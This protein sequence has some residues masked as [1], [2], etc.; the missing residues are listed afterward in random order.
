MFQ[1]G[2]P[3][4]NKRQDQAMIERRPFATLGT[5]DHG[6][7]SARFHF[8]FADY[9][10]P[11]RMGWGVLRVWNNDRI[12]PG[13]GF[14]P[15]GHRD[16]EIVTYVLRGA[17]THEDHLGN[18]GR[19][20]AGQIQVMSA[21]TGIMHAEYNREPGETE[22]F[23]IWLLPNR[24]RVAPRWETIAFPADARAG[25]LV[26]LASGRSGHA[27]ALPLHT[28]G[29]LYAGTLPKARSLRMTL[30]TR[31]AYLVPARGAITVN[32]VA[33][34]ARDGVAID[35]ESEVVLSATEDAEIV[36][37]EAGDAR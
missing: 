18:R 30:A 23:Q 16:M 7:L 35:D 15:H 5:A 22:L 17:V 32:G 27:G 11:A 26:P 12:A 37:V 33:A 3:H 8:S 21:G 1:G 13:S 24:L 36:M 29:V 2:R 10:D 28:D 19:T 9:A 6:W 34:Q 25:R 31:R 4:G 14:P 20:E